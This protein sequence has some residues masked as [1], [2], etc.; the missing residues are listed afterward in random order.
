MRRCRNPFCSRSFIPAKYFYA[1]CSWACRVA[2]VGEDYTH[3]YRGY[4]RDRDQ[5]YDRGF[6]DGVRVSPPGLEMPPGI[7]K[8]AMMLVH[9]DR[10]ENAPEMRALAH[11][12]TV[13]L[14]KHRP[15]PTGRA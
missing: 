4:Q 3:D 8:A 2:H 14:L 10:W 9:P 13:W 6:W 5:S 11:D 12:V 15:Q 7:W 1:Y